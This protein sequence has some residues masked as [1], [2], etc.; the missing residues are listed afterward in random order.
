MKTIKIKDYY[1]IYQEIPVED[2]I[3]EAWKD[4]QRE[5]NA[6]HKRTVYNGCTMSLEDMDELVNSGDED[7]L[8]D[9]VARSEEVQRLYAAIE[10]LTPIQRNRIMMLLNDMSY[11][12]IARSEGRDLSVI[13]RSIGKA[14]LNLRKLLES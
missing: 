12:D 6:R 4:M 13:S 8:F 3:Y 1:G 10:K 2:H 11:T 14:L 5:E 7:A 9:N